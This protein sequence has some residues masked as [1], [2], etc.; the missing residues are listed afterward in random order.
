MG[1]GY[2]LNIHLLDD[3]KRSII[4]SP[5]INGAMLRKQA[6]EK[7]ELIDADFFDL[8]DIANGERKS[9]T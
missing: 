3:T 9:Y 7:L 4:V 1:P 2:I 5:H 8:V 6:I